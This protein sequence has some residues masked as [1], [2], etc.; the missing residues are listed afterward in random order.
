MQPEGL[1]AKVGGQQYDYVVSEGTQKY[2]RSIYIVHKRSAP[3]PTLMTF[4]GSARLACTVKRS[5]TNTPLQSLSLMN[6]PVFVDAARALA[7][8]IISESSDSEP[9]TKIA[10][11]FELC[12]S[13]KPTDRELHRLTTLF[14]DQVRELQQRPDDVKLLTQM[15]PDSIKAPGPEIAAWYSVATVLLNLHETITKP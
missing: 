9:A 3:N 7:H 1:W 2:R 5:R 6:D 10:R 4:D 12:T 14:N 15:T 8:R 13:R 11:G